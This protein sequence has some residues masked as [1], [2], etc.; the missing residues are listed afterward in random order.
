[1]TTAKKI[2]RKPIILVLEGLS[3]AAMCVTRAGG[4]P[5]AVNPR[6]LD[7][8]EA[9]LAEPFDGLL[10]TGG[11]D[12]DP[13]LYGEKP[14]Q[15]VY[16]VSE[17][18]DYTEWSALDE[19]ARLGV[20]VFGICRGSQLMAVHNGGRLRQHILGH[21]STRHLVHAE[22]G[23]RFGRI[24]GGQADRFVSLHHQVVLRHG[25]GFRVAARDRAGHIEAIES[26]DGRCLGVQFHPEMDYGQNPS[27]RRLFDWLVVAAA[28]RA[29]LV[30]PHRVKVERKP[31][32]KP[33][34]RGEQ[35]TLGF[36][37]AP[38]KRGS[39]RMSGVSYTWHCRD[40][41]LKFDH[42]QDRDDHEWAVCGVGDSQPL[43]S[44]S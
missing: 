16:G 8:V 19:A 26:R 2:D 15:Q 43:G 27:S 7:A 18:R 29:G 38:N 11:G 6:S 23:S 13:R 5:I 12:V 25:D 4:D 41:G 20:P 28:K 42:R 44:G 22:D 30:E 33:Y 34:V 37:P 24:I 10:L 32:P 17:V 9:A 14:H 39:R 36:V 40:C 21:R 1:M 35:M 3:G 31:K